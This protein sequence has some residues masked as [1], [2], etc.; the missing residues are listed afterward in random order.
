MLKPLSA[1][2]VWYTGIKSKYPTFIV[3]A[4]SDVLPVYA[5]DT[6][7]EIELFGEQATSNFIV[8]LML[9]IT[10]CGTLQL[11]VL[12]SFNKNLCT[13]YNGM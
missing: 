6:S 9:I 4:L 2:M 8:F 13:V 1:M 12:W 10:P 3:M 7:T 11:K 5:G